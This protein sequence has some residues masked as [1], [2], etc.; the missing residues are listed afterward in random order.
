MKTSDHGIAI[1]KQFEGCKLKAYRCPAHILTIGYGHTTAA[2][3]PEVTE[4]MTITQD[5][6]VRI[7]ASDLGKFEEAVDGM[8]TVGLS[9][10]QFDALVSFA[11]NCGTG[12]LKKSTLL[13]KV[14]A[15]DWDACPAEFMKY[16]RGGGK[17]LPGL[18]RRR[19]AEVESFV[20]ND[21]N[22]QHSRVTPD[23]PQAS[24]SIVQS[25]EGNAAVLTGALG[26]VGVVS[27]VSEQ[28]KDASDGFSTILDLMHQPSFMVMVVI[29]GIAG[30]IWFWRKRR[31]DEE[32]A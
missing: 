24:K 13:K 32:A 4:G 18:V 30:A 9:Q 10:G 17:V 21:L 15:E 31:L 12:A 8:V 1:I 5:E 20:G 3:L 11:Y 25:K 7:L 16:T 19:K 22:E 29:M 14:N 28:L 6:A 27:Q 26:G 2:G 23:A